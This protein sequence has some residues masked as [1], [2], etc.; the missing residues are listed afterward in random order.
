MSPSLLNH[1]SFV[2]A[3]RCGRCHLPKGRSQ[4]IRHFCQSDFGER[5]GHGGDT[6]GDMPSSE[7]PTFPLPPSLP[8]PDPGAGRGGAGDALRGGGDNVLSSPLPAGVPGVRVGPQHLW[9]PPA[10]GGRPVPADGA[11]TRQLRADAEPAPAAGRRLRAALDAPRGA[12]GAGGSPALPPP[13]TLSPPPHRWT[14]RANPVGL[15]MLLSHCHGLGGALGTPSCASRHPRGHLA[16]GGWRRVVIYFVLQKINPCIPS[17]AVCPF[18]GGPTSS[19]PQS[20]GVPSCVPS[21]SPR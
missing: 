2:P 7:C 3:G 15:E 18:L 8:G 5:R 1:G 6:G 9:V 21:A 10:P 14:P 11:E 13:A 16:A 17:L 20:A 19:A 4:R 12:A